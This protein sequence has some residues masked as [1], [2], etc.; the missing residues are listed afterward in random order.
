LAARQKVIATKDSTV[1]V[2]GKGGK[3]EIDARVAQIRKQIE[4]TT[5]K[6][7]KEKLNE[8]LA[9]LSGGVAVIRVGAATE[10]EMKYLKLKIEDAVNATK[11]AIEE[12]IVAGG[13][14][15]LVKRCKKFETLQKESE[16][17]HCA[18]ARWLRGGLKALE[19]PLR[20]I[21]RTRA[22]RRRRCHESARGKRQR[23]LRR[24]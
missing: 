24:V 6:F 7:D 10:T 14:T 9:K 4:D 13:G 16:K 22:R 1:I 8:R 2:G 19:M 23:R 21:A 3:K 20:Q 5:S 15:A 17:C 12:G 18:Y 11:A